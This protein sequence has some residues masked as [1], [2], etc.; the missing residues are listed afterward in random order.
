MAQQKNIFKMLS[1][2]SNLE[3]ILENKQIAQHEEEEQLLKIQLVDYKFV[4]KNFGQRF[5]EKQL[6]QNLSQDQQQLQ[7]SNLAQT[8]FQQLS[9]AQHS[10]KEKN[11]NNELATNF[12]TEQNSLQTAF[13]P[14]LSKGG[15]REEPASQSSLFGSLTFQKTF[16]AFKE[17]V[18]RTSTSSS[19]YTAALPRQEKELAKNS[20][21]QLAHQQQVTT[22]RFPTAACFSRV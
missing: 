17:L 10:H 21:Y 11:L 3:D 19:L 15:S 22:S 2:Q 6:Q 8:T 4:E 7:A 13:F 14:D 16:L 20:F 18:D 9:L 12:E 5:A 1:P